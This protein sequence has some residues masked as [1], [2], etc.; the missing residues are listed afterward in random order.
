MTSNAMSYQNSK[1][2]LTDFQDIERHRDGKTNSRST[3]QTIA[4]FVSLIIISL[5]VYSGYSNIAGAK[6]KSSFHSSRFDK[7]FRSSGSSNTHSISINASSPDYGTLDSLQYLPWDLIIEPYR[8]QYLEVSSFI[9]DNEEKT[10]Q[11]TPDD[12]RWEIDGKTYSG[13]QIT[14]FVE[15]TG[16]LNC[17][18]KLYDADSQ[19][20]Y[21]E[22]FT[23]A[24][25]YIR[26][27]IRSLTAS[28]QQKFIST[29]RMLYD[30]DLTTGQAKF[31]SKYFNAEYFLAK[32]LNGAG[33]TDCDHWHDGAGGVTLDSN[34]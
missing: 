3:T 9:V 29:L 22:T 34:L 18:V 23:L 15:T 30:L 11:L 32:H 10:S 5:A 21:Q 24:V 28:D 13:T 12:V 27:E 8:G 33:K 17:T 4:I 2:E 20:S 1:V 14:V 25:K 16:V 6:S 31:G 26:R 7:V 19:D